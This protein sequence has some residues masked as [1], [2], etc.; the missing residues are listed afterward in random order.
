M[1]VK[2]EATPLLKIPGPAWCFNPNLVGSQKRSFNFFPF[3]AMIIFRFNPNLV[4]SQK[5]R[6]DW[7][8]P[9]EFLCLV[10]ILI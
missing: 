10:S 6:V 2:K 5:R 9:P 1:E 3:F 7:S 4:G 8:F